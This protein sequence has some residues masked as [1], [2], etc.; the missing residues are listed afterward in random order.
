MKG[1]MNP[2]VAGFHYR[3]IAAAKSSTMVTS[4]IGSKAGI[5]S[6]ELYEIEGPLS[7]TTGRPHTGRRY[8]IS[9][10]EQD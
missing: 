9:L 2:C 4:T 7:A 3:L 5:K 10:A 1:T 6:G 8:E